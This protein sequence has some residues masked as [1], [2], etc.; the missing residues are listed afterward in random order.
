MRRPSGL[1][2]ALLLPRGR[3]VRL[4]CVTTVAGL[5]A[6]SSIS[7]TM[8]SSKVDYRAGAVKTKTLEVPPDLTQLTNDP[9]YQPPAGMSIS[10]N[11][12]QASRPAAGTAAMASTSVAPQTLGDLRIERSG[13]QRWLVAP[14]TA[15]QLWPK[16]RDFW[17]RG[18]FTLV[19]DKPEVGV[20][21][22]DWKENRA[23]IPQD[24][25]RRTLGKLVEGLYDSGER[26]RFRTRVERTAAGTEIY[27][28]HRGATEVYADATKVETRWQMRPSSPDLEAEMLGQLMVALTAPADG[29]PASAAAASD[30]MKAVNSAPA[31]PPKAT[32]LADGPAAG[33]QISDGIELAW[34]R[35]GVAL[36]RT[37]FTVEDRDRSQGVYYVRY[38][39]PKLAG[40]EDPGFF[41]RLFGKKKQELAGARYRVRVQGQGSQSSVV[42]IQDEQGQPL[43]NDNA[44]NIVGLLAK[45]LR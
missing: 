14:M 28:S 19:T 3:A 35:V 42:N 30:A 27:I 21:E 34:R 44:R 23:K 43:N 8:S 37:G 29:A 5:A 25:L 16:L 6:C 12:L 13:N 41:G 45:E 36:D 4:L 32:V 11:E 33:L 15:D 31:A 40:E 38:V 18:G 7:D 9:R 20:M 39:D 22:T 26:D 1:T 2:A 17:E 10:A 24:L